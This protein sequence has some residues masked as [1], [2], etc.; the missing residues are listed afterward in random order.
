MITSAVAGLAALAVVIVT[1]QVEDT[2]EQISNSEARLTA[3]IHTAW[4]I[5]GDAKA[6]SAGDFELWTDWE[7]HFTQECRL[8]AVLY[9]DAD[10]EVVHNNFDRATGGGPAFDPAAAAVADDQSP[11]TGKAQVQCEV[12]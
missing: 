4:I 7:R 10:I 12:R 6:A 3:A 1:A 5:E 8:I 2:A 11:G 9:S